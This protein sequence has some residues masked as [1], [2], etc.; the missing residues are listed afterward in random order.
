MQQRVEEGRG[1]MVQFA[2]CMVLWAHAAWR[3][4]GKFALQAL[5]RAEGAVWEAWDVDGALHRHH[6][7]QR[8]Q[9]QA[10]SKD[11]V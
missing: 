6:L 11:F 8:A 9:G 10:G 3:A 2:L 5:S 4:C 7:P 1:R